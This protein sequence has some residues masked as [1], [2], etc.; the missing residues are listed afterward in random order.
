ME[1]GVFG[2]HSSLSIFFSKNTGSKQSFEN[3]ALVHEKV[4]HEL[5]D[6]DKLDSLFRKLTGTDRLQIPLLHN[7]PVLV[8]RD[9]V[10]I[11]MNDQGNPILPPPRLLWYG[12]GEEYDLEFVCR[13]DADTSSPGETLE[14]ETNNVLAELN[15]DD[16]WEMDWMNI[17]GI[18][19]SYGSYA[20]RIWLVPSCSIKPNSSIESTSHLPVDLRNTPYTIREDMWLV[21]IPIKKK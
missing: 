5:Y 11:D 3:G 8:C 7:L 21:R 20:R 2:L 12:I 4:Y 1:C 6:K 15:M 9:V 16:E 14:T 13:L 17:D 18:S 19:Y 10:A